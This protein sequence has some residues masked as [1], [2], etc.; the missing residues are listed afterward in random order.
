M[1]VSASKV[2]DLL[3]CSMAFYLKH[4]LKLPDKSHWKTSVGSCLHNITEY[5]LKPKRRATLDRILDDGFVM[6]DHPIIQRYCRLWKALHQLDL[7]DMTDMENMLVLTFS[8]L[9]PYLR[10]KFLSEQRFELKSGDATISGYVDIAATGALKRILDMK[11]KGQKFTKAELRDNIQAAI[12]QMW[13]YEQYG[14]L[15]PVDFIMV[16]HPPTKRLPQGHLQ[17]VDAPTATHLSGL[18]YYLTELY[19]VMNTFGPE[20]ASAHFHDDEGFCLRVCQLRNPF[21]YVR[22]TKKTGEPVGTFL[23]DNAPQVGDDEVVE[24]L[25]HIG[26]PKFNS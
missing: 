22:I 18:K 9:E 19:Q 16:R 5:L 14:E 13:Y 6:V 25:H 10:D 8:S 1:N 20:E 7:W 3:S 21:D 15:V 2:T 4:V 24:K 17:T 23:L 26:C 12:Y 11:T